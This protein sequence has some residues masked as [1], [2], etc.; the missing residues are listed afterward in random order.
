MTLAFDS[1]W[2]LSRER[3]VSLRTAAFML[4]IDRV[5]RATE[6]GGIE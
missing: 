6:L 4:G 2:D 5:S 1:V 3:K